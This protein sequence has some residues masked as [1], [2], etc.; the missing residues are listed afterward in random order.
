MDRV[1]QMAVQ[2]PQAMH[3]TTPTVRTRARRSTTSRTRDGHAR[4][5]RLQPW[6]LAASTWTSPQVD[7]RGFV[8]AR[9]AAER[10]VH[11]SSG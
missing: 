4:A 8:V 11:G 2:A 9:D 10:D 1:G 6:Q 5:Q 3:W 7:S